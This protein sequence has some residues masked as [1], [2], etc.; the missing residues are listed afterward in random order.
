[1]W[2]FPYEANWTL[3]SLIPEMK[4]MSV[5]IHGDRWTSFGMLGLIIEPHVKKK[6]LPILENSFNRSQRT[7]YPDLS[8]FGSNGFNYLEAE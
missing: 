4:N 8:G 3:L 7:M 2:G 6:I 5:G 1:M